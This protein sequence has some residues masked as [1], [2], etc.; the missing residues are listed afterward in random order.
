MN[1]F[2]SNLSSIWLAR[3]ASLASG[4]VFGVGLL[5]SGMANPDK[6]LGFLDLAGEWDPSLA[7][8]M[9]GA[10]AVGLLAFAI[11][12]KRTLSFLGEPMRMPTSTDIDKKLILGGVLFGLGWGL[13]G[14]CPGPALVS[15][16]SL[17]PKVLLF[18][19]SMLIGMLGFE[20]FERSKSK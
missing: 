5:I 19:G 8:V 6:V 16:T 1:N 17:D 4:F 10:I 12:K 11:S 13:A 7:F 9:G 20:L 14:F 18:V 3:L 15:I 2:N